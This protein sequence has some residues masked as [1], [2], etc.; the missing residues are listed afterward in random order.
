MKKLF[1]KKLTLPPPRDLAEI[2]QDYTQA[3][4]QYGSL[5]HM[6][7]Y[8]LPAQA[9]NLEAKINA[10]KQELAKAEKAPKGVE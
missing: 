7:E 10:L 6:Q 5:K 3:C 4:A 2:Q 1:G 9:K 8:D